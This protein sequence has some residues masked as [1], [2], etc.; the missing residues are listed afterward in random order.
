MYKLFTINILLFSIRFKTDAQVTPAFSLIQPSATASQ[1]T[2][3]P[4]HYF[5]KVDGSERG[6]RADKK[7]LK[8]KVYFNGSFRLTEVANHRFRESYLVTLDKLP[9]PTSKSS[10]GFLKIG[11]GIGQTQLEGLRLTDYFG[12]ASGVLR[13]N[14][15]LRLIGGFGLHFTQQSAHF[16]QISYQH[17]EDQ[18]IAEIATIQNNTFLKETWSAALSNITKWYVGVGYTLGSGF[19]TQGADFKEVNVLMQ[20]AF[21]KPKLVTTSWND[22]T[23]E[24]IYGKVRQRGTHQNLS[25]SIH[26]V[27]TDNSLNYPLFAQLNYRVSMNR[28]FW[29]GGGLNT[30]K[31]MQLQFGYLRIPVNADG[32]N[33][34]CE[35]YAWATYDLAFGQLIGR[36]S[37][38]LNFGIFF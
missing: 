11:G 35:L 30:A 38:E 15:K 12:N 10:I 21:G 27:L 7:L 17:P 2:A 31:R 34:K 20:Y 23:D 8:S 33:F 28:F 3:F 26:K 22:H 19:S 37:Q 18:S 24:P 9:N 4:Y 36:N 16:N 13:L 29:F 25:L 32:G 6:E 14:E 1:P 5:D